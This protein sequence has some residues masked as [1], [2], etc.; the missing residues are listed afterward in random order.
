MRKAIENYDNAIYYGENTRMRWSSETIDELALE[1]LASIYQGTYCD[2]RDT[3][4]TCK[5]NIDYEKAKG[6]LEKIVG[7]NNKKGCSY[8]IANYELANNYFLGRFKSGKDLAQGAF[9]MNQ[10]VFLLNSADMGLCKMNW[11]GKIADMLKLYRA[12]AY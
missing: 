5:S 8:Y 4:E 7:F 1:G 2:K 12:E 11:E 6:Y 9:Y 10:A 3:P